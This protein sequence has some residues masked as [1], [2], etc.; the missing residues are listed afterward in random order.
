M[1]QFNIAAQFTRFPAGRSASKDNTSGEAFRQKFL[2]PY[3]LNKQRV[4]IELDGVIGYG[5]S[6]LEE[7]FGGAIRTTRVT[8]DEFYRLVDLKSRDEALLQEIDMYVR[9]AAARL[10][11]G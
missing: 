11:N 2:E 1:N 6:F 10:T 7:A 8:A 9:D 5:S 3:L 4:T